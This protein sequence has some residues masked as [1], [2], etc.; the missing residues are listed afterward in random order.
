M[1]EDDAELEIRPAAV[2]DAEDIAAVHLAS[3]REAYKGVIAADHLA[4]FDLVGRTESWRETLTGGRGR[5]WVAVLE[6]QVRGFVTLGPSRD[7]DATPATLEI[8]AIYLE[9][10]AWGFGIARELLRT[11]TAEVPPG[12]PVTLW[13]LAANERAR[14]FYR[15]HGFAVDGVER[16]D[17]IGGVPY[18][19]VRY[20]RA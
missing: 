3:L 14:H 7:E 15:R 20:V 6:D 2:T 8:Y 1:V 13:V 5:T 10:A 19:E 9:P 11:V 12:T 17:E 4:S 16:I 18:R